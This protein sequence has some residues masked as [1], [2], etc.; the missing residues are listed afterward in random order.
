MAEHP[1]GPIPGG[2]TA[3]PAPSGGWQGLDP[4]IYGPAIGPPTPAQ[5]EAR[6]AIAREIF[7]P[8]PPPPSFEEELGEFLTP[9]PG[10]PGVFVDAETGRI[11]DTTAPV[12]GGGGA[13]GPTA[14]E[15][16]LDARA[17]DIRER[18]DAIRQEIADADRALEALALQL[19]TAQD[20]RDSAI[21]AGQLDVSRDRETRIGEIERQRVQLERDRFGLDQQ[22]FGL[23]EQQHQLDVERFQAE[24]GQ[25]QQQFGL[26]IQQFLDNQARGQQGIAL[27]A[28]ALG[29]DAQAGATSAVLGAGGLLGSLGA[30]L[31]QLEFQ[32]DELL[33]NLAANPRDFAQLNREYG[34]GT[35]F[36]DQLFGGDP[37]TGQSA[38]LIGEQ[39]LGPGFDAL[40]ASLTQRPEL[41]FFNQAQERAGDIPSFEELS[42]VQV[43]E[44]FFPEGA[45]PPPELG[46]D[47]NQGGAA[48]VPGLL[49]QPEAPSVIPAGV[50]PGVE[51]PPEFEEAL[52]NFGQGVSFRDLLAIQAGLPP[53]QGG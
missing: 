3:P 22:R 9:I 12:S 38:R 41:E 10:R 29:I 51:I 39:T 15:L 2:G 7:G 52:A 16:A 25:F 44:A 19:R 18:G 11:V 33:A 28:A 37:L 47:P 53:Q 23:Q 13:A 26:S 4:A 21:A 32:R 48:E 1:I 8:A 50:H 24:S 43:P 49:P 5:Q 34:G 35:S 36:L 30:D 45:P 42:G 46:F 27:N 6:L 14:A 31:G 17:L 20:E 40:V